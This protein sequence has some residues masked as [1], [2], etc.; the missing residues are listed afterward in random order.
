MLEGTLDHVLRRVLGDRLA[1]NRDEF[2][3]ERA[4]CGHYPLLDSDIALQF[5]GELYA[6]ASPERI[7]RMIE[8]FAAHLYDFPKYY[9]LVYGSD[10]KAEYDFL[11]AC[12]D[13]HARRRVRR[14]FEPA[15]GTGRLFIKFAQ[16]GYQVAGNDLNK[17]A[18]AYCNAR[19]QRH[20][21]PATAFVGDMADF[22]VKRPFDAAYCPI[23]GFR[24]LMSD[25]AA[26][27]H[28]RCVARGLAP[29]GIYL[30]CLHLT[31]TVGERVNEEEWSAR[32]G[33]L[34][35]I[36]SMWSESIDLRRRNEVIGMAFDV[37][38]PTK[39]LHIT[40]F[41]DYRTYTAQQM[42]RLLA[43]VS[44]FEVIATY[45]FCYDID[46]PIEIGPETEDVVYV[47]RKRSRGGKK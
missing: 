19:L 33:N 25:R 31:P 15:C 7:Q 24:H 36:S 10:W 41:M 23:N 44:E 5:S 32:R 34:S 21:L 39:H 47:L 2:L 42:A 35:V 18:V 30:L 38:T 16:A 37:Y 40:D 27:N 45:D 14:L 20:G 9:D 28:L 6:E 17:K 12:F 43:R 1:E 46:A 4:R 3:L 13:S 8:T 29:G 26:E 22:H 11:R